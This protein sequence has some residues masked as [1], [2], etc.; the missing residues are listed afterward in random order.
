MLE[1]F[2]SED[3]GEMKMAGKAFGSLVKSMMRDRVVAEGVR[4]DGRSSTDIREVTAEVGVLKRAHGSALFKRGETQVLNVLTM[5][6]PRMEQMLDTIAKED[7]KSYM[8]HYNFPPFSTGG[9]W[10]HAG[11]QAPRD[12]PRCTR[13]EG[14]EGCHPDR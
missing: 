9:G 12:R 14:C 11:P 8:H 2:D 5:G 3:A 7:S 6:M 4:M 13:R 10:I 1:S